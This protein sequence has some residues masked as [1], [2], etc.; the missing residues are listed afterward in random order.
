[1]TMIDHLSTATSFTSKNK[2][3]EGNSNVWLLLAM[4]IDQHHTYC[5]A[6]LANNLLA[7]A[8]IIKA[9][10]AGVNSSLP[11]PPSEMGAD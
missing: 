1:M 11:T 2:K 8:G 5:S 9:T 3:K 6:L 4:V 10:H 7:G